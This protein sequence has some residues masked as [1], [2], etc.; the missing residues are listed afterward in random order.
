[1]TAHLNRQD[2]KP[3]IFRHPD[4]SDGLHERIFYGFFGRTGGVS[5]GIFEGLNCGQGSGDNPEDIARNRAIVS[6]QAGIAPENLLSLYQVHGPACLTVG[7]S[8]TFADRPQADAMA[9][10][11]PGLGLGIL[12]ADCAP[13]LFSAG[14]PDGTPLIAAAHAGWKGAVSGVL[15]STLK[16]LMDNGGQP[17]SVRACIGPC[18]SPDSYEV[19]ED[20]KK[21]FLDHSAAASRFFK[22]AEKPE[23]LMFDLPSYCAWRLLQAGVKNVSC[24]NKDTCADEK[25]FYSYR[26]S[27]H[28]KEPDYGRQIALIAIKL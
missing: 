13:V 18:I 7:S 4:F 23:H 22:K 3:V 8:W 17:S 10:Q 27:T 28:R 21:P 12:V 19:S 24:L 6:H 20:F 5:R 1:M 14:K 26:R 11:K 25:N 2:S 9:T 16:V 15:E